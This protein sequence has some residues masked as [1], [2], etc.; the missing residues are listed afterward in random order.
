M[1]L[2]KIYLSNNFLALTAFLGDFADLYSAKAVIKGF[3]DT[4]YN[5]IDNEYLFK[6]AKTFEDLEASCAIKVYKWTVGETPANPEKGILQ[7]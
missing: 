5:I 1:I 3:N 4:Q 2:H 6:S 7:F